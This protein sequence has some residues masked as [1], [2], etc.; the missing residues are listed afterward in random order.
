LCPTLS[1]THATSNEDFLEGLVHGRDPTPWGP[2]LSFVV[3][4][5]RKI[6]DAVAH[7]VHVERAGF[8]A[9]QR[10]GPL[11]ATLALHASVVS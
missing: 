3:M 1:E 7:D 6:G 9:L 4:A 2:S 8:R 5:E 11:G 10:V